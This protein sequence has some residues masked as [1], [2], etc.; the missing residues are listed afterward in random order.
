MS[1]R[2][3]LSEEELSE[4]KAFRKQA[5]SKDSEKALMVLMNDEGKNAVEIAKI[6]KRHAHT[7]RDWIKRFREHGIEGL[8]RKYSPG[9]PPE[10]RDKSKEALKEMLL[11]SPEKYGYLDTVW[12]IALIVNA[13][14]EHFNEKVSIDTVDRALHDMGYSYKRPSKKP[15]SNNISKEEKKKAFDKTLEQIKALSK[16]ESCEIYAMDE[17]HFSTEPY[18]VRGWFLKK[19]T[20]SNRHA[21]KTRRNHVFWRLKSQDE[22]ALLEKI[23]Y[24]QK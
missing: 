5:S 8:S 2:I 12:T 17:T 1:I 6:L 22:E 7:V 15:S 20:T 10:K 11:H 13:L 24:I 16:R 23:S 14:Q 9:R 4:L 18:L 3:T 21:Q 19:R